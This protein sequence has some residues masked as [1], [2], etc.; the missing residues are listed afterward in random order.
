MNE[1]WFS[2]L[3]GFAEEAGVH[4]HLRLEGDQ[5]VSS[6]DGRRF[7]VGAFSTP[8]LSEL[9]ALKTRGVRGRLRLSHV[10]V[11]DALELHGDPAQ[12]GAVFQ[13]AS[14]FNCLEFP[15]PSS[16]PEHG[17]SGYSSDPTQ[18]PACS[19]AAAPATVYRND[20]V[21]L[22]GGRGQRADRQIEN[23]ADL[24]VALG[25]AGSGVEVVNGYTFADEA[26]LRRVA[27]AVAAADREVL[28]G[29]L[30]VG[31]HRDVEVVFARRF[32][33]VGRPHRVTQVFCSA[34]SCGYAD[35]APE[36]WGPLARIVLDAAYEATLLA[37]A[38]APPAPEGPQGPAVVWLTLLGGG[39]FG[40]DPRWIASAIGR[41]L[42]RCADLDLDVR[43]AHHRSIDRSF[44]ALVRGA[45]ES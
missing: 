43:V 18:G 4:R 26:S 25:E 7:G 37:A 30:R 44:E 1:T 33:P 29:S 16:L 27:R 42:R 2:R 35:V 22:P 20:F 9:R 11:G 34:L 6:L 10:A 15:G 38:S 39:V 5:L 14:Q 3:F 41:A 21:P 45:L 32:E 24:L 12:A 13:V 8:S 23:L 17:V 36:L 19:L 40:N 28:L 31:L